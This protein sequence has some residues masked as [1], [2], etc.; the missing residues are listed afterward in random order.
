M[1]R[2]KYWLLRRLLSDICRKTDC[3]KK[4]EMCID[5]G[6]YNCCVQAD[7]HEQARKAWRIDNE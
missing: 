7:I 4:C 5:F 2:I 6:D 3:C 1:N